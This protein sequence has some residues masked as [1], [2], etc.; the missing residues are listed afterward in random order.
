MGRNAVCLTS[1]VRCAET[2]CNLL[3]TKNRGNLARDRQMATDRD[4][5]PSVSGRIKRI[6]IL[7]IGIGLFAL[8]GTILRELFLL[9]SA[10]VTYLVVGLIIGVIGLLLI[11][12]VSYGFSDNEPTQPRQ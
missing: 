7:F 11:V 6:A 10:I 8:A 5:E 12:T 2:S 3:I 4:L 9:E 1:L